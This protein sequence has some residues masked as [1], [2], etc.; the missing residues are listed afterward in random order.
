LIGRDV[1][2]MLPYLLK[3]GYGQYLKRVLEEDVF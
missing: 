1:A 3:N 2:V